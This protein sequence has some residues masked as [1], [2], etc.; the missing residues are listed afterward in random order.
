LRSLER[1]E[2]AEADAQFRHA[3]DIT[4][5]VLKR[6]IEQF[7]DLRREG[8]PARAAL[9]L[10][11]LL[12]RHAGYP[13][14]HYLLGLAELEM[15]FFDDALSSF[16]RA[17]ELNPDFHAARLQLARALNGLGERVQALEQVAL[18]LQREPDHALA[19]EL[20]EAWASRA[21]MVPGRRAS[22]RKAS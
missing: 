4:D 19:L 20:Q 9:R 2:W 17:L 18:V 6:E 16:A 5:P 10:Q 8:S 14:L 12:S 11:E 13:D 7:H 21:R 1:A 22:E 15:G 3:L